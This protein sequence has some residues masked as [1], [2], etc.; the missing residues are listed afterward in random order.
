MTRNMS[1]TTKE[2]T[3]RSHTTLDNH[4][5]QGKPESRAKA[6]NCLDDVAITDTSAENSKM[7]TKIVMALVA[8]N[9]PVTL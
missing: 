2:L 9:D 3:G 6:N 4:E 7:I 8:A 1:V 5:L